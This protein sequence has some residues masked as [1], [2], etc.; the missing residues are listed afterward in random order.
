MGFDCYGKNPT[1][2]CGEHFR[3]TIWGWRP[4]HRQ[5]AELC[6]DLLGKDLLQEMACNDG[7]GPD[8][9]DTCTEIAGRLELALS[10][11]PDG[12]TLNTN[13]LRVDESGRFVSEE[14]LARNPQLKTKSP[15]HADSEAAKRWIEFL[16]YCGGFKVL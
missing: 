15:Y 3:I 14:E 9:Q 5:M 1:K 7:A 2:R 8:D 13:L 11:H 4:L 10:S 16:R 12:F 6:S